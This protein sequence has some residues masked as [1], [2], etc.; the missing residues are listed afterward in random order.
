MLPRNIFEAARGDLLYIRRNLIER[1]D[2][3]LPKQLFYNRIVKKIYTTKIGKWSA[4]IYINNQTDYTPSQWVA[5]ITLLNSM[6][7]FI[8]ANMINKKGKFEFPKF[9]KF[10]KVIG[11]FKDWITAFIGVFT[12]KEPQL[13]SN[14]MPYR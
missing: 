2:K 12:N 9:W 10:L 7:E 1:K 4:N 14:L 13:K 11:F 5:I 3:A 8:L 6:M